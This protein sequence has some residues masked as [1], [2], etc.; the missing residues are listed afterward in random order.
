MAKELV[1]DN[2]HPADVDNGACKPI[3]EMDGS[4]VDV[5]SSTTKITKVKSVSAPS[6]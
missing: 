2:N 4:P 5:G 1:S 3:N 6:Y